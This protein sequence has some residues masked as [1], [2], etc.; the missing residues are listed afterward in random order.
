MTCESCED[1]RRR[2]LDALMQA[3]IAEALKQAALGAAEMAGLKDK[4]DG[5]IRRDSR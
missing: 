4:D 3:K 5:G 1:R 2:L